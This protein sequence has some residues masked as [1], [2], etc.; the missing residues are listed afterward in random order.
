MQEI[1]IKANFAK[2]IKD[3]RISRKLNQIQLGEKINYSSKAI[4]KWEN[5]DVLPDVVVLKMLAD[6]F[7]VTV[8]DLISKT[9]VVKKSHKKVNRLLTTIVSSLVAYLVAAIV[10]FILILCKVNKAWL[11]FIYAI[12]ASAITFLVFSSIW[13]SKNQI[14]IA[15]IMTVWASALLVMILM[16]FK[17][18]WVILIIAAILSVLAVIFFSIRFNLKR[19]RE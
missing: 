11:S 18:F 12:P 2:N 13:Y 19:K 1:D 16:S 8:D 5:G 14:M 6:F 3:L 9:N 4:S 15:S 10:F 17:F 7:D